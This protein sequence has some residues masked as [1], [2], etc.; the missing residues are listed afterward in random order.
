MSGS[1]FAQAAIKSFWVD[2]IE[3][4]Q[5]SLSA[6]FCH[7]KGRSRTICRRKDYPIN[8]LLPFVRFFVAAPA[9]LYQEPDF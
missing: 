9:I 1:N 8:V 6:L 2:V 7:N 3:G 4:S 5:L